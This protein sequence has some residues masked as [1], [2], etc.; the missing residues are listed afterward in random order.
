MGPDGSQPAMP[1][2]SPCKNGAT[3]RPAAPGGRY[4]S[5]IITNNKKKV[6]YAGNNRQNLQF[7][8][9]QKNNDLNI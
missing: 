8:N 7:L 9:G 4:R 5:H 2:S 6:N 3:T 1:V